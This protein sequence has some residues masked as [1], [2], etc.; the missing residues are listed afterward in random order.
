MRVLGQLDPDGKQAHLWIQNTGHTWQ[1]VVAGVPIQAI[2][3]SVSLEGFSPGGRYAVHWW[4]TYQPDPSGQIFATQIVVA[5]PDGTIHL[6][7][8][9]LESDTA[10]Q[11]L[12]GE[13]LYLP[14]LGTE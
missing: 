13:Q 3:G 11:I 8:N 14:Y 2:S 5:E 4:D 6:S 10:V 7:I 9:N 12:G 1:N